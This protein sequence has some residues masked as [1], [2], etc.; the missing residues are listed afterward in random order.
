MQC[1]E[2]RIGETENILAQR[3]TF[4][5]ELGFELYI[6]KKD[7]AK[8]FDRVMATGVRPVG[9]AT[10]NLLSIEKGF[11]HWSAEITCEDNPL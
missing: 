3:M 2:I 11:K 1:K 5:G 7:C 8:V 9:M 6:P 10:L 4:A